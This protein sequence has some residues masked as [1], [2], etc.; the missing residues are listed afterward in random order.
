MDI[1]KTL[2]LSL[3]ES[4]YTNE[5]SK[6][7]SWSSVKNISNRIVDTV[8]NIPVLDGINIKELFSINVRYTITKN[9][10]RLFYTD[11]EIF[12]SDETCVPENCIRIGYLVKFSY[13]MVQYFVALLNLELIGGLKFHVMDQRIFLVKDSYFTTEMYQEKLVTVF[14]SPSLF[15]PSYT[16]DTSFWVDGD[17]E[18]KLLFLLVRKTVG[19]L[20]KSIKLVDMYCDEQ[21]KRESRC[22]RFVYQS[23]GGVLPKSVASRIHSQLRKTIEMCLKICLR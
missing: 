6:V 8:E 14:R 3:K 2:F 16:H 18:E 22:Y 21:T 17:F 11:V 7:S 12:I 20:V 19:L 10:C 15:P 4:D 13:N 5:N 23:H 1:L 9:N